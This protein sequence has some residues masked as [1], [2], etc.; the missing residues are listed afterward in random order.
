MLFNAFQASALRVLM[1][2]SEE[3][4]HEPRY[5]GRRRKV[6]PAQGL[7]ERR[8]G[9]RC[10]ELQTLSLKAVKPC[11]SYSGLVPRILNHCQCSLVL[12]ANKIYEKQSSVYFNTINGYI[13]VKTTSCQITIPYMEK[14]ISKRVAW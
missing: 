1:S 3:L 14:T 8:S 12:R 6:C 7:K 9:R 13:Q 5:G 4:T 11:K 10:P 2:R